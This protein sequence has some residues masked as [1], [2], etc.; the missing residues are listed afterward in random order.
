MK[1]SKVSKGLFQVL[2]V[3]FFCFG[4]SFDVWSMFFTL[5][6]LNKIRNLNSGQQFRIQ[7]Q[8]LITLFL[9]GAFLKN[10]VDY[11]NRLLSE[12]FF[13]YTWTVQH[14]FNFGNAPFGKLH[15]TFEQWNVLT[16]RLRQKHN[17]WRIS[18]RRQS[19][20]NSDCNKSVVVFCGLFNCII[21]HAS[22][23]S[24]KVECNIFLDSCANTVCKLRRIAKKHFSRFSR[25]LKLCG[26]FTK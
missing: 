26:F 14:F 4:R 1:T 18:L 23:D 16:S 22:Q 13:R 15:T 2:D 8:T 24:R 19:G 12:I 3:G 5:L 11:S 17:P 6:L 25:F 10:K 21:T 7:R 9:V 20:K